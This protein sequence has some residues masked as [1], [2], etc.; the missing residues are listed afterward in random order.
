MMHTHEF[1]IQIIREFGSFSFEGGKTD[2]KK[3]KKKKPI[4]YFQN[5]KGL[6]LSIFWADT[7]G[8]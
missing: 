4:R 8:F 6:F 7:A 2:L 1:G 3:K 5:F